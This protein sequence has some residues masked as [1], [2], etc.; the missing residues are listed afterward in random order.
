MKN[1]I[2]SLIMAVAVVIFASCSKSS[3]P[4]PKQMTALDSVKVAMTGTWKF[5]SVTVTQISPSKSATTYNCG[6]AELY[7][8]NFANM[9]WKIFTPEPNFTYASSDSK[10]TIDYPCLNNDPTDAAS[11]VITQVSSE[12]FNIQFNDIG[13]QNL[14]TFQVKSSDVKTANIKATLISTGGVSMSGYNVTYQFT[15]Q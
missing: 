3:D 15:K 14:M 1:S 8:A 12:V 10:A 7:A 2:T 11:F 6:R 4:T 5:A 13:T 9:N